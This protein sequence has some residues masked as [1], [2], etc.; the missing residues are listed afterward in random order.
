[1]TAPKFVVVGHVNRGK[2]SIV[3]T[4]AADDSVAIGADPGTTIHN[5]EFPCRVNGQVHFILVDT[6]GFERPRQVLEELKKRSASTADRRRAVD[7]FMKTAAQDET[8]PQ[9]RELLEAVLDSAGLLYVIDATIPPSAKYEAEMQILQWT[10]QPRMALINRIGSE[11]RAMLWRSMLDQYFNLVR[12][13][14]AH[15][16]G[17]VSRLGLLQA[18]REM[19]DRWR[20]SLDEA[21]EAL[22]TSREMYLRESADQIA[23]MLVDMLTYVRE[24]RIYEQTNLRE[25]KDKLRSRYQED[26]VKKERK[27]H[28]RLGEIYAHRQRSV[29]GMELKLA[30][31][32]LFSK[33]TW[34]I[35]GLST[36]QLIAA[37]ALAG[38]A[39]GGTLDAAVGG[40][41]FLMGTVIGG[42]GGGIAGYYG[43]KSLPTVGLGGEKLAIGP[44]TN[45][46]FPWIVLD[47]AVWLHR[48]VA[49]R[50]HARRDKFD[51]PQEE[52]VVRDLPRETHGKFEKLFDR[53]RR[54]HSG[55]Q[56]EAIR[57]ELSELI[58]EILRET[59]ASTE[60]A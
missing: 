19:N 48:E 15:Q 43:K 36:T 47:R 8:Y 33:K 23:D 39:I 49:N 41:S 46:N 17:F 5:R 13:F 2:S 9:E 11:D 54:K 40:A 29:E 42:V 16:A 27:G 12:D 38:A 18:I 34:D 57:Y 6:P 37:G 31:D 53:L 50:P 59:T 52:S 60:K 26:L 22:R 55:E 30:E 7:D 32:D 24:R 21:I 3:S 58:E 44:M 4:L 10:G 45:R 56:R 14:D 25:L 28:A 51:L 1:M 35:F 20:T